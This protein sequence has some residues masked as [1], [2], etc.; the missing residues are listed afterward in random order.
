MENRGKASYRKVRA[1]KTTA[2][3]EQIG[4]T[5]SEQPVSEWLAG[6]Q[7]LKFQQRVN[8]LNE[9]CAALSTGT[10][11][12]FQHTH[13]PSEF[14][15]AS[16]SIKA[17]RSLNPVSNY[18]RELLSTLTDGETILNEGQEKLRLHVAISNALGLDVD[19]TMRRDDIYGI[20]EIHP[21]V[22]IEDVREPFGV[23]PLHQ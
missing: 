4:L 12:A 10:A 9:V 20:P 15:I 16:N 22:L 23:L 8:L 19:G 3:S 6:N 14:Y 1:A 17:S 11:A 7:N 13:R 5:D 21:S 2:N 18:S